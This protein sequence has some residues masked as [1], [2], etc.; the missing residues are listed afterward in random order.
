MPV[1]ISKVHNSLLKEGKQYRVTEI[2]GDQS[3]TNF[4]Q[5]LGIVRGTLITKNY[6]PAYS[7]LINISVS[8]KMLSL[9]TSDFEHIKFEDL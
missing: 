1:N 8:A 5:T 7:K 3:F 2:V 4:L 9:K 6:S